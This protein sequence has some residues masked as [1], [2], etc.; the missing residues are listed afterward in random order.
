[1]KVETRRVTVA[2]IL[3]VILLISLYFI[4]RYIVDN[5]NRDTV[6]ALDTRIFDQEKLL[7]SLAEA[8]RV[9]GADA[10]T[11]RIIV[12][13]KADERQQ[14]DKLLDLLSANISASQLTELNTLFYKCG[15]FYSDR[16]SVM[17]TRLVRE[18]EVLSQYL[19]LR[20]VMSTVTDTESKKL[21]SWKNLAEAELKTAEY[22]NQLVLLQGKIITELNSGKKPGSPELLATL[23]D[24]NNVRGQMLILSKQIEVFKSEALTL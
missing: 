8:T 9:N 4:V 13:C 12:D 6:A 19:T 5:Q 22:F 17:A 24:V 1:M 23:N 11:E 15:S 21:E 16:K 10:A 2:L 7:I 14:F 3:A 18:V 20:S